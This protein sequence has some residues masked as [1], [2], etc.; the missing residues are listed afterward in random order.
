MK[1]VFATLALII[2]AYSAAFACDKCS[3]FA[4][5]PD[6]RI[7]S[8][9]VIHN[10]AFGTLE[11]EIVVEGKAGNTLPTAVGKLDMA[12]VLA[13]VFPT[14]LKPEDVGFSPTEGIVALALT[15]HPDFDD[16]PLWDENTDGDFGNDGLTWH[17]HWV[18]LVK[19]DRVKGGL[20]VKEYKQA[21]GV[22]KPKT[23][24]DMPM[25]MDS[26]GFPVVTD[27]NTIR[28]AV[29]AYRMNNQLQFN[30]DAVTCYLEVSA[31][32]EGMNM[33]KPMLG[34]YTV[35]SVLSKDLSLPYKVR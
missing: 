11:F 12:P 14:S 30:Y 26:P 9:K 35:F 10:K 23:A 3:R 34:V 7:K 27:G 1:K 13:Y 5:S 28:V 4:E 22:T 25:F 8:A 2:C 16:S 24:P 31:P 21:D 6:F 29:P 19:D 18:V 32:A 20:A 17:P 33:D 15:A